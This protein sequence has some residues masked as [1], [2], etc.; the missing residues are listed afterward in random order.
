MFDTTT[1]AHAGV[2]QDVPPADEVSEYLESIARIGLKPDR[3]Q[4]W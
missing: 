1:E 2:V 4:V 3:W